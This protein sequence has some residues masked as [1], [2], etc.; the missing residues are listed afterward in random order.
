MNQPDEAGG[1]VRIADNQV[2]RALAG[3]PR[4][5]LEELRKRLGLS[6]D[7][8]MDVWDGQSVLYGEAREQLVR[9]LREEIAWHKDLLFR[10]ERD[11]AEDG[12]RERM[13]KDR[14]GERR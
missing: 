13:R 7:T 5:G 2:L 10:L 8:F 11:R 4:V 3:G 14:E 1:R 6:L 12:A 9:L